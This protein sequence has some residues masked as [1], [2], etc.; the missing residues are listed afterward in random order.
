[1]DDLKGALEAA[2]EEARPDAAAALEAQL[3]EKEGQ[4]KAAQARLAQECRYCVCNRI[5]MGRKGDTLLC[6]GKLEAPSKKCCVCAGGD[7]TLSVDCSRFTLQAPAA[8]RERLH[9]GV[10]SAAPRLC[11]VW[12][13]GLRLGYISAASPRLADAA[14]PRDQEAPEFQQANHR[15]YESGGRCRPALRGV[16]LRR[17]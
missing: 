12:A 4:L 3:E 1:M 5:P 9:L 16:R 15:L 8:R 10:I 7:G 11:L 14:R 2:Q 6:A 13:S 17:A